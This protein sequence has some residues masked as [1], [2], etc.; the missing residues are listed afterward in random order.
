MEIYM[1]NWID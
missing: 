1:R